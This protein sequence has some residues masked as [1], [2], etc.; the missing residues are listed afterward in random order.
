MFYY[1][2]GYELVLIGFIIMM[3]A[4]WKVQGSYRKY[5]KIKSR[6][7]LTGYE[8]A[9]RILD[10][11]G[12]YDVEIKMI[13]GS[14]TDHYNPSTKV[15]NLSEDIYNGDGIASI[16]VGAH[17]VGH[18]IQHASG[19]NMLVMRNA[20]LP[21]VNKLQLP[22]MIALL[23]GILT[24]KYNIALIGVILISGILVFQLLT[25]PVE[26]NAS[27]RALHILEQG[28]ID[29]DEVRG[30]KSMLTAAALTYVASAI[31]SLLQ[32]LRLFL[33]IQNNRNN[34]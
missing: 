9:R 28:M 23:I 15:V 16:A 27:S 32:V 22:G 33:V 1:G 4:Q 3:L 12:L 30:A 18:A 26:I 34:D 13:P 11:N 29:S 7:G 10:Q 14:L 6:S 17:E 25:L 20:I 31:S 19:Y 21:F 8:T 2:V 5:S 24:S